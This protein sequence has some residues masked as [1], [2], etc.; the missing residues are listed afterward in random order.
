M[1]K[2]NE[3]GVIVRSEALD[4]GSTDADIKNAV[5]SGEIVIAA[6]GR[7][8]PAAGLP[9]VRWKREQEIYRRRCLCEAAEGAV[10]THQSAAAILGLAMLNP[11]LRRIHVGVTRGSSGKVRATRHIH[12]GLDMDDVV[13]VDGV[14]VTSLERTAV[15]VALV[16]DFAGALAVFDSALRLG[17]THESLEAAID[18]RRRRGSVRVRQALRHAD[19]GAAN[20]GESW[21]RAQMI[22]NG[23]PAAVLQREVEVE[24]VLYYSDFE[25]DGLVIGE[26]DGE[27]KYLNNRRPGE[28]I[29][30]A[31]IREKNRENALKD[32]GFDL[33]RWDWPVLTSHGVADR[34]IPH[35][36][37]AGLY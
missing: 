26:F 30:Q 23:L 13:V 25:W 2:V 5:R 35:L 1:L 3:N 24:G 29:A 21:S 18:G 22:Q 37:R 19:G 27:G 32:M 28:T 20:P 34:V 6:R 17:A 36:R 9:E 16:S 33:V 15:D 7:Y 11:D 8:V 4:T 12:C 10:L 31:V 14:A